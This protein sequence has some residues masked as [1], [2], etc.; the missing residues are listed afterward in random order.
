MVPVLTVERWNGGAV[1]RWNGGTVERK[2]HAT[3]TL[4]IHPAE[5]PSASAQPFSN[6]ARAG[7]HT[8]RDAAAKNQRRSRTDERQ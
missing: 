3:T 2:T 8:H 7:R 6:L 5:Q 4:C 1:E